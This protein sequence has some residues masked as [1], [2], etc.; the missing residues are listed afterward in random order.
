[1]LAGQH[2]PWLLTLLTTTGP[3]SLH[4]LAQPKEEGHAPGELATAVCGATASHPARAQ[5]PAR[6]RVS[7]SQS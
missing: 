1:M 3:Q 6:D 4:R 2:W 7:E 5:S